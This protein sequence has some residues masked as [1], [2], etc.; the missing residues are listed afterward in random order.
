MKRLLAVGIVVASVFAGT[1]N[2]TAAEPPAKIVFETGSRL[3]SVN[4]DGTGWKLLTR[5]RAFPGTL[6]GGFDFDPA[7]SPDGKTILFYRDNGSWDGK[8]AGLFTMAADGSAQRMIFPERKGQELG[9]ATWSADGSRIYLSFN[10]YGKKGETAQ[11]ISINPDGTGRT[12]IR[13]DRFEKPKYKEAP[14]M[15]GTLDPSP[16]GSELLATVMDMGSDGF[17]LELVDIASGQKRTLKNSALNG[18]WSP[19]GTKILF[20]G[21]RGDSIKLMD[22]DGGSVRDLL[23]ST[24]RVANS[25]GEWSPDGSRIVF[26]RVQGSINSI[27]ASEV[28][29]VT[30]EGKCLTRLTNGTPAST[31]ATWL[32]SPSSSV[33]PGRCGDLA[34]DPKVDVRAPKRLFKLRPR[35]YWLGPEFGTNMLSTVNRITSSAYFDY[36]SCSAFNPADCSGFLSVGS[37]P[38]CEHYPYMEDFRGMFKFRGA[39]YM[40]TR[41]GGI[42]YTGGSRV[43]LNTGRRAKSLATQMKL[44]KKIRPLGGK[45]GRKLPAAVLPA[46]DVWRAKRAVRLWRKSRSLEPGAKTPAKREVALGYL[47]LG[48]ALERIG[49]VRTV[50]CKDI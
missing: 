1:G 34:P 37:S 21:K 6:R 16:D 45:A 2:G 28:W 43:D 3:A 33:D 7:G 47:E 5:K 17:R 9:S 29:T 22:A 49:P 35:A 4:A 44:A 14:W 32:A 50:R 15:Y 25:G 27:F 20:S 38:V 48:R 23:P 42:I 31:M 24:R 30:P 10:L 40:R 36:E 39:L 41:T 8:T 46:R 18:R 13:S 19:D 11:L 26:D 12:V